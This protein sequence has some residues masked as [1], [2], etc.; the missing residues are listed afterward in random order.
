MK[1]KKETENTKNKLVKLE[2]NENEKKFSSYLLNRIIKENHNLPIK[3]AIFN[4]SHNFKNLLAT[5]SA[6]QVKI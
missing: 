4:K 6:K 5:L 3:L 1:R 2:V